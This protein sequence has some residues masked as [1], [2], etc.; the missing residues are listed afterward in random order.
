MYQLLISQTLFMITMIII[1]YYIITIVTAIYHFVEWNSTKKIKILFESRKHFTD[2]FNII[3]LQMYTNIFCIR[4][5]DIHLYQTDCR[6]VFVRLFLFAKAIYLFL[7]VLHLIFHFYY[8][9]AMFWS[10]KICLWYII[11][12]YY[13]TFIVSLFILSYSN[14]MHSFFCCVYI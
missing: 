14:W 13:P 12:F 1:I 10:I 2:E 4:L 9:L 6:N 5:I 11:N 8:I 3:L 7:F